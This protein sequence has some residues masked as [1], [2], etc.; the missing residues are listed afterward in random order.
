MLDTGEYLSEINEQQ[1]TCEYE[2]KKVE[3]C[4]AA[5]SE[6]LGKL[7]PWPPLEIALSIFKCNSLL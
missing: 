4:S 3:I 6:S 7:F 5:S 2:K 1:A